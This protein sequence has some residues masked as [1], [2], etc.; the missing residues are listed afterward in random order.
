MTT[1]KT[2][3]QKIADLKIE[4]EQKVQRKIKELTI[5]EQLLENTG[6]DFMVLIHSEDSISIW[7]ENDHYNNFSKFDR[8]K[9]KEYYDQICTLFN[10]IAKP[11]KVSGGQYENFAPAKLQFINF[12]SEITFNHTQMAEIE[13]TFENGVKIS[14]K[15]PSAPHYNNFD[16]DIVTFKRAELKPYNKNTMSKDC[17]YITGFGKVHLYGNDFYIYA[18]DQSEVNDLMNVIFYGK[19]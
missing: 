17:Y 11:V 5:K 8:M 4:N 12:F 14:F 19:R 15:F 3:E 7:I 16:S 10:P 1:S 2:L 9:I 18:K 6:L 13:F